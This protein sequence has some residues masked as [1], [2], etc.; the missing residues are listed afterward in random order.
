L[1]HRL[2]KE[3]STSVQWIVD[4]I[5]IVVPASILEQSRAY[6]EEIGIGDI[7]GLVVLGEDE[8]RIQAV[9][10]IDRFETKRFPNRDEMHEFE[11]ANWNSMFN[12]QHFPPSLLYPSSPKWKVRIEILQSH[13]GNQ[14]PISLSMHPTT[15]IPEMAR[16]I[17]STLGLTGQQH[18]TQLTVN[19]NGQVI[20]AGMEQGHRATRDDS[21]A[22]SEWIS[23]IRVLCITWEEY[24]GDTE[25]PIFE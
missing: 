8:L 18:R 7:P 20:S 23:P 4:N 19:Q 10:E 25:Y 3:W 2:A 12:P 13:G 1:I 24:M 15:T 5:K 14:D 21:I 16:E 17:L 9:W 11:A 6:C 22:S